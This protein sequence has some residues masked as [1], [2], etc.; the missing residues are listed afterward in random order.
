MPWEL[1][2]C[3]LIGRGKIIIGLKS[4][5]TRFGRVGAG[6]VKTT[7]HGNTLVKS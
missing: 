7:R 2:K 5:G 6:G 3:G 1:V 4:C